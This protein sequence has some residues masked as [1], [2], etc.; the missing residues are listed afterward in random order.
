MLE[1][2]DGS[3]ADPVFFNTALP[4]EAWRAGDEFVA[5]SD[6]S[7]FRILSISELEPRG[8]EHAHGVWIVEPTGRGLS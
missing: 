8:Y 5:G 3:G 1:L 4:P 7:R 6:L 2:P